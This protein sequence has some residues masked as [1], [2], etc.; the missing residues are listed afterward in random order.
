MA[1]PSQPRKERDKGAESPPEKGDKKDKEETLKALRKRRI[2]V[3][4]TDEDMKE[5]WMAYAKEKRGKVK[6][7]TRTKD[8]GTVVERVPRGMLSSL[9]VKIVNKA[10][11]EEEGE[12]MVT[13]RE[14]LIKENEAERLHMAEELTRRYDEELK[15][16][17]VTATA[18]PLPLPRPDGGF[19]YDERL[20]QVFKKTFPKPVAY[21]FLEQFYGNRRDPGF[22]FRQLASLETLGVVRDTGEGY[23]WVPDMEGMLPK[24]GATFQIRHVLFRRLPNGDWEVTPKKE[25]DAE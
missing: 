22:M 14:N 1:S 2:D 15:S 13:T 8:D 11:A 6:R 12:V 5:K 4:L 19:D 7:R 25:G 21:K 18:V 23:E 20:I 16:Y 24:P 3:Y 10:I 17:R 9:I